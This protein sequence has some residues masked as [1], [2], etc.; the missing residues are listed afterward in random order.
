MKYAVQLYTLRNDCSNGAEFL[1][2]FKKIKALGFDGVEFAGF[3]DLPY[4]EIRHALD[5]AGLVAVGCH[6]GTDWFDTPEK[7][8]AC[9]EI[10]KTLGMD[11]FGV[12]GAPHSTAEEVARLREIYRMA[13][14]IG[15]K[16]GV[17]FYYHN[18]S[19]EFQIELDGESVEDLIAKDAYLEIDTYWSHHAGMDNAALI[20]RL[21]DRIVHL[22]VKD[23]I[24]GHPM[25]LGE[26]DCDVQAVLDAAKAIDLDW[27]VL[28]NDDPEPD[29][30][31][32]IT[33]SMAFF[34]A[35][36]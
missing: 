15:E 22:H 34:R 11:C 27:V 36:A 4:E 35:H 24:G 17:K 12:G 5:E 16:E 33:R 19:E 30:F 18:H 3:H 2:Q 32:D 31:S 29:G 10:A 28:E 21:A 6:C 25:A 26:G 23:G 1:Q 14:E 13:N 20:R 8:R 7:V 9:V